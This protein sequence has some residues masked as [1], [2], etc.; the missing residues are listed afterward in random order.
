MAGSTNTR[1]SGMFRL[2]V[3]RD[4]KPGNTGNFG[5][6]IFPGRDALLADGIIFLCI[7]VQPSRALQLPHYGNYFSIHTPKYRDPYAQCIL[8]KKNRSHQ[9]HIYFCYHRLLFQ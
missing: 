8:T 4:A 3:V 6:P 2:S 7:E 1:P 5:C 9:D